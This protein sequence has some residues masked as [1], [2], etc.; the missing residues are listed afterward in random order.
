VSSS[1]PG[2]GCRGTTRH[3]DGRSVRFRSALKALKEYEMKNGLPFEELPDVFAYYGD[4]AELDLR[5]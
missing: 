5:Q 4:N 2:A 1:F 3:A